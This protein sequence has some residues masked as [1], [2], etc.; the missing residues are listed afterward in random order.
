MKARIAALALFLICVLTVLTP[1]I[2]AEMTYDERS[3]AATSNYSENSTEF[4]YGINYIS[5]YYHYEPR[6]LSDA[7][8]ERDF[9]LFQHQGL[10]YI[11]IVA[12]WNYCE[13]DIG[14]YD[15]KAFDDM[16]RVC[17]FAANHSLQVIIDFQTLM[18]ENSPK[19]PDWVSPRRF[20]TVFTNDTVHQ[21]W[22]NFLNHTALYLND[23]TNIY[24]WHMMNEPANG[25]WACAVPTDAFID[26]WT[27][28]RTIFKSYSDRP[29]SIRFA[30]G[31]LDSPIHFNRDPRIYDI[32]DYVALNWYEDQGYPA[33]NLTNLIRDI[34]QH[35]KNVM[36]SEFG[37]NRTT[38]DALQAEKFKEYLEPFEDAGVHDIVAWMW[39]ADCNAS[40]PELPG[41][42][43]DLAKSLDGTPRSA[44]FLLRDDVPPVVSVQYPKNR[45]YTTNVIS[46]NSTVTEQASWIGYSLDDQLNVTIVGNTTLNIVDGFHSL[47]VFAIDA[48]GNVGA[49]KKILFGVDTAP[50]SMARARLAEA[51]NS[52]PGNS[53]WVPLADIN[54]DSIVGIYDAILLA[55][56]FS[57]D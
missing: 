36:I 32:C 8:L 37:Y 23:L 6:Y 28:M 54:G 52:K 53:N 47:V 29:V 2:K 56:H 30:P 44:F 45:T 5:A 15:D 27:Q 24:S 49:S 12:V 57:Q 48:A 14:I 9:T 39:R 3:N 35:G 50:P 11:T 20:Q 46:L 25:T 43:Y 40:N 13:P 18:F 38:D 7:V 31:I 19:I 1:S 34:Q 22:L 10:K 51:F 41:N 33:Q 16:K 4:R 21:A 42:E 26:L 17:E 55:N